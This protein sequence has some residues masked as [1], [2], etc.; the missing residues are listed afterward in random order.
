[1]AIRVA[2]AGGCLL[3]AEMMAASLHQEDGLDVVIVVTGYD[4]LVEAVAR[5]DAKVAL[6]DPERIDGD[7][8]TAVTEVRKA[9]PTCEVALS[10]DA[11]TAGFV[12]R[13]L[14]AGV[15]SV[16]PK[17]AGLRRL[18]ESVRGVASGQVVID[19]RLVPGAVSR[20]NPLTARE[21]DVLRLTASGASVKEMAGELHLS[22]GRIR[23]LASA[24]IKKLG[25]RNR[26]DAMRIADGQGWL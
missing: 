10:V 24:A 17:S 5:T 6:I 4:E 23:N 21:V 14:R 22:T 2:V 16:V 19:P 18:I 11:P 8:T 1:M 15:L 7:C 20:G 26:Y 13:V 3:G 9:R 25:A 12:D